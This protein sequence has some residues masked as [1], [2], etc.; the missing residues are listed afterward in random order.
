MTK[1]EREEMEKEEGK[2]IHIRSQAFVRV[3]AFLSLDSH[4]NLKT[5]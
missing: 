4:G 5:L 1:G 2:D 3:P